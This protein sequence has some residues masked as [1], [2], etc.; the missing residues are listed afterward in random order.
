M[1]VC[2]YCGA[3]DLEVKIRQYGSDHVCM[4][5]ACLSRALYDAHMAQARKA[6]RMTLAQLAD[7]EKVTR[8]AV[9]KWKDRGMPVHEVGGVLHVYLDE[10]DRWRSA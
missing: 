1:L 3:D 6:E 2:R 4:R 10:V 8:A 7:R 9:Y 5:S